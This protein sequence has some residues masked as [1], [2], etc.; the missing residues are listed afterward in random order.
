MAISLTNAEGTILDTSGERNRLCATI[1]GKEETLTFV[2]SQT[3]RALRAEV[4]VNLAPV[5]DT[6]EAG[7]MY[8]LVPIVAKEK[9][10]LVGFISACGAAQTEEALDPFV[11]AKQLGLTEEEVTTLA[12]GIPEKTEE[13]GKALAQKI[14]EQL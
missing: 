3:S 14:L 1:R 5:V 7:F 2:C 4:K 13:E 8:V 6:C 10:E 12:E 11:L 9:G